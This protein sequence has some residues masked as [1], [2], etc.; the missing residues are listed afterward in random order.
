ME[1]TY[2]LKLTLLCV[3]L[4]DKIQPI[5]VLSHAEENKLPEIGVTMTWKKTSQ[6][7]WSNIILVTIRKDKLYEMGQQ[8][9]SSWQTH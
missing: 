2:I 1:L 9:I 4:P 8:C 5:A 6:T 7:T 3:G